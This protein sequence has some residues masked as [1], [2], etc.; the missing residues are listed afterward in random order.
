VRQPRELKLRKLEDSFAVFER[1]P[2][3]D[4]STMLKVFESSDLDPALQF[5]DGRRAFEDERLRA[6]AN[7]AT[8]S[9]DD[10]VAL[11]GLVARRSRRRFTVM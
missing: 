10:P 9:S 7:N 11:R 5:M 3:G 4:D 8:L 2:D 6:A 1:K